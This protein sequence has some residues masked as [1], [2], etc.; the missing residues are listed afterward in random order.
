MRVRYLPLRHIR[1]YHSNREFFYFNGVFYSTTPVI[2]EYEI[3]EPP[4]GAIVSELPYDA[5]KIEIDDHIYYEYN[6]IIYKKVNT[7]YGKA[8]EVVGKL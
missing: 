1:I 8:Y 7:Q 6:N 2:D 3:I 5:E 4:V